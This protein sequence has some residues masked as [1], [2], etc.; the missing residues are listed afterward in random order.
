MSNFIKSL[1]VLSVCCYSFALSAQDCSALEIVSE[2]QVMTYGSFNAKD[3]EVGS[4]TTTILSKENSNGGVAIEIE[5][6]YYDKKDGFIQKSG[7]KYTCDGGT[8]SLDMMTTFPGSMDTYADMELEVIQNENF[9]P[10]NPTVGATLDDAI[11]KVNI[12]MSGNQP[13]GGIDAIYT[14]RKVLSKETL[15]TPAG[16][17][18]C[19]KIQ[20]EYEINTKTLGIGIPIRGSST[21]YFNPAIGM[22]KTE[23]YN[24]KGKMTGYTLLTEL[25]K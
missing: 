12:T 1:I 4:H 22:I 25:K 10:A 24:K 20:S 18:E 11:F 19:F 6:S 7:A 16:S 13:F 2:G 17:F 9:L 8:I 21:D 5:V 14:N 23:S 15:T 3:K